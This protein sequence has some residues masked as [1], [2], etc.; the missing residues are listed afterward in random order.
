MMATN[1]TLFALRYGITGDGLNSFGSTEKSGLTPLGYP[2]AGL[3][4]Q[5]SYIRSFHRKYQRKYLRGFE[6]A[7]LEAAGALSDPDIHASDLGRHIH[8]MFARH[9]WE[10]EVPKH[11]AFYPLRHGAQGYWEARNDDV[12]RILKPILALASKFVFNSHFW[13]WQVIWNLPHL[14]FL[15]KQVG[16]P[17]SCA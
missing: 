17:H 11:L 7:D 16:F 6:S 10:T 2:A 1:Q 5:R 15:T 14:P 13:P 8:P 3:N 12:W 4:A 9:N